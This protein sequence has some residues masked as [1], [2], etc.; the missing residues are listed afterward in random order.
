M[1]TS[2]H[3]I[4]CDRC[5]SSRKRCAC[6][7]C[8]ETIEH[9]SICDECERHTDAWAAREKHMAQSRQQAKI[10]DM[11]QVL[12]A[13]EIYGLPWPPTPKKT[14]LG[15]PGNRPSK[16]GG[17]GVK[18]SAAAAAAAGGDRG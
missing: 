15:P 17:G 4:L 16:G 5:G 7:I 2:T 9:L 8:L 1:D 18:P 12:M 11:H 13:R 10:R 3:R 14:E 6:P